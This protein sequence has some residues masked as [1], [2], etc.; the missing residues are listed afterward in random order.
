[1]G[2]ARHFVG[3][4]SNVTHF[5]VVIYFCCCCCSNFEK[6]LTIKSLLAWNSL[7]KPGWPLKPTN[8]I[9]SCDYLY[10][11]KTPAQLNLSLTQFHLDHYCSYTKS[12][13]I[14]SWMKGGLGS[15]FHVDFLMNLQFSCYPVMC[16]LV[17]RPHFSVSLLQKISFL[18]FSRTTVWFQHRGETNRIFLHGCFLQLFF[19]KNSAFRRPPQKHSKA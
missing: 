16:L 5:I 2:K 19:F 17:Q 12:H 1:M 18:F 9:Y 3:Q 8:V 10:I 7:W 13:T 6:D 15:Q 4:P 11:E 14:V